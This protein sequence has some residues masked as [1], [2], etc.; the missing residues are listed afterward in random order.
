MHRLLLRPW[1][2]ALVIIPTLGLGYL[3]Y[4]NLGSGFMPV[5]DEG[6]F[7]IDYNARPG[8]SLTETDRLLR[9]VEGILSALE[10]ARIERRL[11]AGDD[12][13]RSVAGWQ[14]PPRR[15]GVWRDVV[16]TYPAQ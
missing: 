11:D 12:L 14:R 9:Q 2:V 1:L 10:Y 5:M 6:G 7:I 8:T 13:D 4:Q 16:R 3:A 15:D